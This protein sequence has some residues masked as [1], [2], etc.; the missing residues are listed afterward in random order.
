MK[1][2]LAE[3]EKIITEQTGKKIKPIIY[4]YPRFWIE[5]LCNPIAFGEYPL[6]IAHYGVTV[7]RMPNCWSDWTLHQYEGDISHVPG[8]SGQADLNKFNPIQ[9]NSRARG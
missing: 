8:V 4:T 9:Q 2:W 6:W 3:V 7:P 1:L 5:T